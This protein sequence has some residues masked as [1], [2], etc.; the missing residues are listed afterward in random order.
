MLSEEHTQLKWLAKDAAM[1]IVGY[2]DNQQ[3][4]ERFHEFILNKT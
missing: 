3:M 1:E 2:K 4:I